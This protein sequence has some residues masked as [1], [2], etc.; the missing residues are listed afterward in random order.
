MLLRYGTTADELD[1]VGVRERAGELQISRHAE[2]SIPAV[3]YVLDAKI[4]C[5]P[6]DAPLFT[7]AANLGH[8][9]L[10][11]YVMFTEYFKSPSR[12]QNSDLVPAVLCS[13]VLLKH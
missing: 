1:Q 6:G 11:D 3:A 7:D 8:V 5:H 2:R 9:G 4:M 12:I 10:M 13:K